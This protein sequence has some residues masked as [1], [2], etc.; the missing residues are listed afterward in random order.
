MPKC[1]L[2]YF[3][4]FNFLELRKTIINFYNNRIKYKM[5]LNQYSL[6]TARIR[7]RITE[8]N[9]EFDTPHNEE[10]NDISVNHIDVFEQS[11]LSCF[12]II[13]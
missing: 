10:C 6:I 4:K 11:L 5:L 7:C 12:E 9:E 13:L 1:N 3:T 8:V 2:I